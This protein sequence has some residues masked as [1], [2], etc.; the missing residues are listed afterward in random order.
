M[1]S[2]GGPADPPVRTIV[3]D[4]SVGVKWFRDEPGSAEARQLLRDHADG[5]LRLVVPVL[6][7]YEV[8]DVVRRC[9]GAERTLQ[10]W[11]ALLADDLVVAN[12]GAQGFEG[13]IEVASRHGCTL[14]DA[15]APAL[16]EVLECTLVSADR[17]A[18]GKVPGVQLIG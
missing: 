9:F 1:I 2:R 16:A 4:A 13:A 18:H 12:P 17:Y 15:A 5:S 10:V 7:F 8:L 14:C 6:F 3:L 11:Q